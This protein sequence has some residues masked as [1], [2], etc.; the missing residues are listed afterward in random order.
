MVPSPKFQEAVVL[1]EGPIP[2]RLVKVMG[3]PAQAGLKVKL[4]VG[5][6][7]VCGTEEPFASST[8]KPEVLPGV[9]RSTS[10]V[11]VRPAVTV[12]QGQ[13]SLPSGT[14]GAAV[15]DKPVIPIDPTGG[16]L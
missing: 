16:G 10:N 13:N 2:F 4:G 9:Q 15:L 12:M 3:S 11:Y 14:H 6:P 5:G 7:K 8:V 1:L